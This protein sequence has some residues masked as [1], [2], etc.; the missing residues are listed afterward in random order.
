M[1]HEGDGYSYLLPFQKLRRDK[2]GLEEPADE[3]DGDETRE[4]SDDDDSLDDRHL[5]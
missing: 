2:L 5:P 1:A 3:R 4:D